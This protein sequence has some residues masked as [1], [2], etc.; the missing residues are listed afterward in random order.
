LVHF[1]SIF[2]L[3]KKGISELKKKKKEKK[4]NPNLAGPLGA[5]PQ[6]LASNAARA[7]E[8]PSASRRRQPLQSLPS[9]ILSPPSLLLSHASAQA[10]PDAD[11]A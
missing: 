6:T 7:R 2:E 1:L 5:H 11:A 10:A 8:I 9:P 4:P 3:Y